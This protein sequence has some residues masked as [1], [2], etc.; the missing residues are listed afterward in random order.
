MSG[1]NFLLI[2]AVTLGVGWSLFV[3]AALF[4]VPFVHAK[5]LKKDYE[6]RVVTEA[7]GTVY[8]VCNYSDDNRYQQLK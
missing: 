8:F 7:K 1:R 2:A 5:V 6:A 3:L 4:F